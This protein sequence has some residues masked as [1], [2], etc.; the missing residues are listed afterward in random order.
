[1]GEGD[2]EKDGGMSD[3]SDV[4]RAFLKK[5]PSEGEELLTL[6]LETGR[7]TKTA[8]AMKLGVSE[9]VIDSWAE[10]L[11][12]EGWLNPPDNDVYDPVFELSEDALKRL[13]AL[14]KS[15]I[16]EDAAV[17]DEAA[18]E[19]KKKQKPRRGFSSVFS[20]A[21]LLIL[22]SLVLS[23]VM[24]ARFFQKPDE[25]IYLLFCVLLALFSSVIYRSNRQYSRNLFLAEFFSKAVSDSI[26]I[27]KRSRR[28]I[29]LLI[30]IGFS[31]YFLGRLM[32]TKNIL[33]FILC[34]MYFFAIPLVFQKK[35]S[36]LSF[37]RMYLGLML[38]LY[39]FLLF[40]GLTSLTEYALGYKSRALDF[41]AGIGFLFFLRM[42]ENYFGLK[43]ASPKKIRKKKN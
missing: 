22:L 27:F 34:M 20:F 2:E 5:K 32:V 19:K 30:L 31:V 29:I 33:Y 38:V 26:K 18:A 10:A 28:H 37:L 41:L 24:F 6:V 36:T 40:L 15:F 16:G 3:A 1:M 23:L 7:L 42:K 12:E 8:C 14:E 17:E 9:D 21:D 11:V 39:A 43:M 35:G 25:L 4:V 13:R